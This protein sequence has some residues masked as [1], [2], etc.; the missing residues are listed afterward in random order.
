MDPSEIPDTTPIRL[1]WE[2]EVNAPIGKAWAALSDTDR[3]NRAA[4]LSFRFEEFPQEAG[5]T[6]R[7]GRARR[8]GVIDL[9]WDELRFQ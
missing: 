2:L 7:V 3:F 6:K 8:L 1:T 4:S 9:V 5:T